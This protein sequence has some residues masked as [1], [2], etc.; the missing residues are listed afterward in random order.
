M[1]TICLCS[2]RLIIDEYCY[3]HIYMDKK[4]FLYIKFL[5]LF[6]LM[7]RGYATFRPDPANGGGRAKCSEA[8]HNRCC[9]MSLARRARQR[10][11]RR[12]VRNS[13]SKVRRRASDFAQRC[14]Y[15]KFL[16]PKG[17]KIWVSI[18]RRQ[19]R[20]AYRAVM[21]CSE[22]LRLPQQP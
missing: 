12:V 9:A 22:K 13:A 11:P 10:A 8:L 19:A 6:R 7:R 1:R 15:A 21:C 5:K 18:C 3:L 2:T 17:V 16:R 4:N 20:T 14:R